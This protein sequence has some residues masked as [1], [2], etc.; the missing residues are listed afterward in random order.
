MGAGSENPSCVDLGGD[1]YGLSSKQP[2]QSNA[3]IRRRAVMNLALRGIE[4]DIGHSDLL[5]SPR[6]NG[7]VADRDRSAL[8]ALLRH[9]LEHKRQRRRELAAL[10]FPEKVR[11]VEQMRDTRHHDPRPCFGSA[12]KADRAHAENVTACSQCL[13][14]RRSKPSRRPSGNGPPLTT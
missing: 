13:Q 3:T 12:G 7:N 8:S 14:P 6:I 1:S 4:V 11:I 2:K 10:P 5:A 9:I